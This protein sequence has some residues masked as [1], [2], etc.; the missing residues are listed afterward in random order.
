LKTLP[1]SW[2]NQHYKKLGTALMGLCF[3]FVLNAQTTPIPTPPSVEY[4]GIIESLEKLIQIDNTKFAKKNDLLIKSGKTGGDLATGTSL[5]V[6]PDY[7][8]SI[9]LHSDPGY[10]KLASSNKCQFYDSIINDLLR[11]SEGKLKNVFVTYVNKN[12]ERDSAILLKKDFINK[13]VS[14][15]CPETPKLIDQFQVKNLDQTIRSVSFEPPSGK[16][17]CHNV[18]LDW[19]NNPKTPYFCKLH[20]FMKEARTKTGDPKDLV[21]RQAIAA[22]LEK[23][24]NP[25]QVNYL[26]NLCEN[27]DHEE[28]FCEDF[29]TVSFWSKVAN[30][31]ENKI[32]LEDICQKVLGTTSLTD[33][34]LKQCVAKIRKEND[35]CLYPAGRNQGLVPAPQCDTLATALNY[36]SLRADYKDNPALSDQQA[37]T[38]M[39]RILLNISKEKILPVNGPGS[40]ISSAITFEFNKKF[41]NDE[42]WKL[43]ACYDDALAEREV[44]YKTFFG[45]YGVIPESY[46]MV[47]SE[48]LRKSRGA[49]ASMKCEMIDSEDYNPLLLQYKSGCYI[50]YERTKCFI[51]QCKHKILFNDRTIDFIKLKN[52]VMLDY[53]ATNIVD[54][55][56]S[57]QY[58]LTHDYRQNGRIMNNVG[59]IVSFFK[60][61]K[62]GILHGV[63]CAEDLLPSFFK[64]RA[65]NQCT[66]LP[67]IID[68]IIRENE[69]TVFV[70]RSAADTLQAPRL[71][72]WSLIY[73]A[74]KSY[75][76]SHPLRLWTLYGL[77]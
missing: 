75:Q 58:I 29:L 2:P 51:S 15:E 31:S 8:N 52:R 45:G 23:K 27:L 61:S 42:N 46:N 62:K 70:T 35:H 1:L 65:F 48:I 14:L 47:V 21:Q 10:V 17:Q 44:C 33:P 3:S 36:S 25:N 37:V 41:D 26:E 24:L 66:P 22:I 11:N 39:G 32:Y 49:D 20:E 68:G 6:D 30:G 55:R 73:S 67:F 53:F 12:K 56:F 13:V 59:S 72:S 40:V 5:E 43:E 9:I 64:T 19:L 4:P 60:K 63:G 74:V 71:V 76:Q 77:D 28:L 54:E 38:N 18:Y 34:Q 16:D 50:I 69:K 57:Q 7:L